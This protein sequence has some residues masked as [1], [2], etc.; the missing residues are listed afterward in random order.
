[1]SVVCDKNKVLDILKTMSEKLIS[2]K[3][4]LTELDTKIGDGDHGIS[5]VRGFTAIIN[6]LPELED[7]DIGTILKT[8][9]MTLVSTVG[10]ASG[11]LLGTAFMYAGNQ[12]VGKETLCL[13]DGA[14]IS[15]AALDGIIKEVKRI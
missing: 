6:K 2:E 9:G 14:K 8:L 12:V 1:M 11:P 7:K 4:Y 3:E 15:K 13:E 10:G 5:M